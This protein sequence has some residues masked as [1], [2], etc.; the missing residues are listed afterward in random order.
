[1]K[2]GKKTKAEKILDR[3]FNK[4]SLK[5]HNPTTT[6]F[7]AVLN[8]KPLVEVRNI[9]LKGKSFQVPFPLQY[10]RQINLSLKH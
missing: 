10:S 1:M 8:V 3:V 4:I 7:L 6:L 5:G 2:H 9:R